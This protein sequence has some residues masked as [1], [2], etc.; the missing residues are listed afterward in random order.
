MA[1][2]ELTVIVKAV[3]QATAP[4]R[5]ITERLLAAVGIN[6]KKMLAMLG[7]IASAA[8]VAALGVVGLMGVGGFAAWK[9]AGALVGAAETL[10]QID[11]ASTRLGIA[12]EDLSA[13]RYVAGQADVDFESLSSMIAKAQQN[14]SAFVYD[15]SGPAADAVKRLGLNVRDASGGVRSMRDLLPEIVGSL[16]QVADPALRTDLVRSIFGKTGDEFIQIMALG[17]DGIRQVIDQG[18]RLGVIFSKDQTERAN[19]FTDAI[20]RVGEA[21]LGVK[22]R[23]LDLVAPFLMEALDRLSSVMAAVPDI[24]REFAK[25]FSDSADGTRVRGNLIEAAQEAWA[26][27]KAFVWDGLK[28]LVRAG[29]EYV[30]AVAISTAQ[31]IEKRTQGFLSAMLQ[32]MGNAAGAQA[33]RTMSAAADANQSFWERTDANRKA[34]FGENNYAA[35]WWDKVTTHAN[36]SWE[37]LDRAGKISE[38]VNAHAVEAIAMLERLKNPGTPDPRESQLALMWKGMKSGYDEFKR[39]AQDV[40]MW[41]DDFASGSLQNLSNALG[42]A[43]VD[44]IKDIKN[45]A[46]ITRNALAGVADAVAKTAAQMAAARLITGVIGAFGSLAGASTGTTGGVGTTPGADGYAMINAGGLI[47]EHGVRRFDAGGL[48]PGPS[49]DRDIVPAVLTPGERVI[50]RAVSQRYPGQLDALNRGASPDVAFGSSG[51]RAAPVSLS[52]H[53]TVNVNAPTAAPIDQRSLERSVMSAVMSAI[54]RSPA[55][56]EKLRAAIA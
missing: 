28:G 49:V 43:F 51:G 6:Q 9:A 33:I 5:S 46:T 39:Q 17:A 50:R 45:W 15:G 20:T 31:E 25:V 13:L 14:L 54:D 4:I 34:I 7:K 29:S 18:Q 1:K 32:G 8:K 22:V 38:S 40:Q 30:V 3:D 27:I 48:V 36:L 26:T 55:L 23:V 35:E 52:V 19:A 56:R 41:A 42:S 24:V 44:S 16:E 11:N 10:E 12:V 37:A 47:T 53:T 2:K 21:W